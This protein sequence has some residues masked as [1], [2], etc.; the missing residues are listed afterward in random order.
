MKLSP[1]TTFTFTLG[2]LTAA[3]L[4]GCASTPT[5]TPTPSAGVSREAGILSIGTNVNVLNSTGEAITV[6]ADVSDTNQGMGVVQPG[7]TAS[8]EGTNF[9]ADVKLTVTF[10]D[11]TSMKFEALNP[12]WGAGWPVL[13]TEWCRERSYKADE[14]KFWFIQQ[15]KNSAQHGFTIKRLPDDDWKQFRIIFTPTPTEGATDVQACMP[16]KDPPAPPIPAQSS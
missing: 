3:V 13:Q 9:E 16:K 4:A 1:R 5:S 6:A 2:L 12:P 14:T 7:E 15:Y 10:N 8:A 11:G